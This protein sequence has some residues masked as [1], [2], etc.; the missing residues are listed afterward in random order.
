MHGLLAMG[1]GVWA[2]IVV[3]RLRRTEN[4]TLGR[5]L[6]ALR[7]CTLRTGSPPIPTRP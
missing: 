3:V 1:V 6:T 7:P 2:R 4:S 5:R